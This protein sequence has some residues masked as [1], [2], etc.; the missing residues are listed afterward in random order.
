MTHRRSL[1]ALFFFVTCAALPCVAQELDIFELT[2]FVDPRLRGAE[3]E[4]LKVTEPGANYRFVRAIAG[5]VA[6]Y[7]TRTTP[8]RGDVSFLH[9]AGSFYSG[10]N[11]L[12]LRLTATQNGDFNRPL[13]RVTTQY[14][15]YSFSEFKDENAK[16]TEVITDRYLFSGVAEER[17]VCGTIQRPPT[18]TLPIRSA[19]PQ[20]DSTNVSYRECK[21]HID[22]ELAVQSDSSI[23]PGADTD[24]VGFLF[25]VRDTVEEGVV[26]R[27]TLAMRF[28]QRDFKRSR[29][30]FSLDHSLENGR[31]SFHFGATR[32][33]L[34]YSLS[35]MKR[36][37]LHAV[38][39][40]SYVPREPGRRVNNEFGVFV[41][42]TV[43]AR[44]VAPRAKR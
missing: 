18:N 2:D 42:T 6:N 34:G 21:R 39:Q 9:L 11:Q 30:S 8:T 13:M 29:F 26:Y 25:G 37:W 27:G 23:F 35:L 7:T 1:A 3:V 33:S 31:G 41:D 36:T 12:N 15:R 20:R 14:A 10:M 32:A 40:P 16:K 17:E 5:G 43:L 28:L 44:V 4:D 19:R 24:F 38:W 22:T